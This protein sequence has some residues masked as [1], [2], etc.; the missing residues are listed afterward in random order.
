MHVKI[1]GCTRWL[2]EWTAKHLFDGFGFVLVLFA[3]GP[4]WTLCSPPASLFHL[5]FVANVMFYVLLVLT[6]R[7][8]SCLAHVFHDYTKKRHVFLNVFRENVGGKHVSM[9]DVRAVH[10]FMEDVEED[11]PFLCK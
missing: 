10:V 11:A 9:E 3:G 7:I 4:S 6:A 2:A 5:I 1:G 8:L